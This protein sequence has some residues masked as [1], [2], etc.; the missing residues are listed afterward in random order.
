MEPFSIIAISAAVGGAAARMTDKVWDSG[1]RWLR[2]YFQDHHPKAQLAAE[3]NA[4]TFVNELA[5][6][7]HQ[8]EEAFKN[9]PVRLKKVDD[10]L[11]DPDFSALL[12]D[13]IISSARTTNP[14]RHKILAR[15]VAERLQAEPESL[16]VMVSPLACAAISHLSANHLRFLGIV[17]SVWATRP[18]AF[19]SISPEEFSQWYED[20]WAQEIIAMLPVGR[21]TPVD[22][23]HLVA[24]SCISYQPSS[25]SHDIKQILSSWGGKIV[26][27][28][29][30][31]FL[32]QNSAGKQLNKLWKQ[33]MKYAAPTSSGR[34]IG[35]YAR[36][37]LAGRETRIDWP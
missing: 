15:L 29:T 11:S 19:P 16:V 36:D 32:T 21:M 5:Q 2:G 28:D 13:A 8:L 25:L 26:Q 35:V 18:T 23:Y 31:H 27:W 7:F 9:D 10:A 14:E 3:Q 24:L 6:R 30:D 17:A 4:L 1:E 33:G 34:L 37:E 12:R 22:Y 20:W